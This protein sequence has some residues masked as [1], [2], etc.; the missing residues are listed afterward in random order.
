MP[1]LRRQLAAQHLRA[2][3]CGAGGREPH[4]RQG[5]AAEVQ[6]AW[7]EGWAEEGETEHAEEWEV[8][9]GKKMLGGGWEC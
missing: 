4:H 5:E 1:H 8:A 9:E 2:A 3:A 7:V 6:A